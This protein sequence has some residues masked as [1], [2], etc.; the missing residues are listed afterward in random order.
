MTPACQPRRLRHLF[1]AHGDRLAR[2][3]TQDVGRNAA[4][5]L[6]T[7][8]L[9][10]ADA[11]RFLERRARAVLRERTVAGTTGPGG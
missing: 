3:A 6:A 9:P 2:T 10:S 5:V 1:A 4:E 11:F 8:V 7:D